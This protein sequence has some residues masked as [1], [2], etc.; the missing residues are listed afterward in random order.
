MEENN[1]WIIPFNGLFEFPF[2]FN[3][4]ILFISNSK[5]NLC[6]SYLLYL[7]IFYYNLSICYFN[8]IISSLFSSFSFSGELLHETHFSFFS[9]LY[10]KFNFSEHKL[11]YFFY[12]ERNSFSTNSFSSDKFWNFSSCYFISLLKDSTCNWR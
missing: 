5:T 1:F 6:K 8:L 10:C 11:S 12:N 4:Y 3:F 2:I 7:L 9:F